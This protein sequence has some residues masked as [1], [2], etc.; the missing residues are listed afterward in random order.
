MR[1]YISMLI[2]C[3]MILCLCGSASAAEMPDN[4]NINLSVAN[5]LGAKFNYNGDNT[6][7]FFKGLDNNTGGLNAIKISD[8][9]ST[10]AKVNF[11]NAQSGTFYIANT[12]G[13]GYSD[14]G[15]LMLAINGTLPSDFSV[16]ITVS[17]YQWTPNATGKPN[18]SNI[19]YNQLALNETFN[20]T[21]FIYGP[22]TWRNYYGPNYPI[23]EMQDMTNTSNK[24]NIIIIDLYAGMLNPSSYPGLINNGTIK[25]DYSITNLP[26]YS[27]AAFNAYG[28][29]L[30]PETGQTTGGIAWTNKVNN[31]SQSQTQTSGFY[32]N[33]IDYTKPKANAT[34]AGGIYNTAKNIALSMSEAGNIYYT[35]DNTNPDNT[36]T[37]YTGPITIKTD[38]I[39]KFIAYD[40][41]NNPSDIY[42][43][44]YTIDTVKPIITSINPVNNAVN[45][46]SNK[47]ITVTF[48][49]GIKKGNNF[50]IELKNK[51]GSIIS[52]TFNI[53]GN[54]LTIKPN[55]SLAESKYTLYIHTGAVTDL[56]GNPVDLKTS[57]FSVGNSP[58]IISTN[59]AKSSKG[60]SRNKSIK[61]TLN[62]NIAKGTGFIELISSNGT[63]IPIT[64]S[65]SG[66]I[67]TIMH[68][69]LLAVKTKYAV[70]LHTGC[71]TDLAGNPLKAFSFNFTT[72]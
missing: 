55:S 23:Y 10:A 4:N 51:A 36:S 41:A 49:E 69:T 57:K 20:V 70:K 27:L 2:S 61:I 5:D 50:F 12:G 13:K 21:D 6:Y 11:T 40:L 66:K 24:F 32:V 59:P 46:A 37:L 29:S 52:C 31:V 58:T 18:A 43:E 62:E 44:I 71:I 67:L 53:S 38:T 34:P 16:L 30:A 39:L 72:A 56:A 65:I 45:V 1:K 15:I 7:S 48:N 33:G 26:L 22:Q 28:Y 68:Q 3:L 19:V 25:V 54:I 60:V 17:G 64:Y 47:T 9:N 63:I 35:T 42:T 8:D 14:E